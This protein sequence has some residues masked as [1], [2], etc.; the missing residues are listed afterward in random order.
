MNPARGSNEQAERPPFPWVSATIIAI[1]VLLYAL[2]VYMFARWPPK[3]AP[4]AYSIIMKLGALTTGAVRDRE[5]WRLIT[6][7]FVHGSAMH[8]FFN[9]LALN[10][11]GIPLERR[12]GGARF[13]ELSLITCLGGGAFVMLFAKPESVTV[14]SSGMI[15]GYAGALLVMLS[16]EQARQLMQMLLLTAAISLLPSVSW[17]AHLGGFLFG[18]LSGLQLRRDPEAF[19]TRAPVLVGLATALALYGAY[20]G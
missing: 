11:L 19:S 12:I 2:R 8:I 18:L 5:W 14:G 7:A 1:A 17:Q 15:L 13:L 4:E 3:T 16:R 6:H 20:R 9:M 10:A